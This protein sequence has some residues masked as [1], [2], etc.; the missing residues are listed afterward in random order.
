[1]DIPVADNVEC[2]NKLGKTWFGSLND[3]EPSPKP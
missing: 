2:Y 3:A 1:M